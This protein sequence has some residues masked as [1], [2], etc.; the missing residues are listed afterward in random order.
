MKSTEECDELNKFCDRERSANL[1]HITSG[2]VTSTTASVLRNNLHRFNNFKVHHHHH[3]GHCHDEEFIKTLDLAARDQRHS[4]TSPFIFVSTGSFSIVW[5]NVCI[6][7]LGHILH[8]SSAI[9]LLTANSVV[10][11]KTA[12][13]GKLVIFFLAMDFCGKS[14]FPVT[15]GWRLFVKKSR[16]HVDLKREKLL[17]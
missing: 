4:S 13:Y 1:A 17:V 15:N 8:V 3:H 2:Q 14:A 11:F 6:F 10:P 12:I 9:F 5:P 7:V 16:Q